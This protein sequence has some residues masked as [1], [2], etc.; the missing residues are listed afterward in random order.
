MK[1]QLGEFWQT[2]RLRWKIENE[3]I[4]TQKNGGYEMEHGYGLKGN[5]WKNYYLTLQISQL[6]N[7]LVRFGDLLQKTPGNAKA[8]FL[9]VFGTMR[10]YAKRL[11]ECLRNG[12]PHLDRPPSVQA[13]FQVRFLLL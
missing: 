10:N 5:A 8:T 2:G 3:G 6:L 13:R 11:I 1:V 4:N 12:L 7:D 9:A